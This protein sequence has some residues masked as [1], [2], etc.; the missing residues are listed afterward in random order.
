MQVTKNDQ[1]GRKK[2]HQ[3]MMWRSA[4]SGKYGRIIVH[5]VLVSVALLITFPLFIVLYRYMPDLVLPFDG[6]VYRLDHILSF[7]VI[8]TVVRV[9]L[10]LIEH[11]MFYVMMIIIALVLMSHFTGWYTLREMSQRYADLLTLVES[12]PVR[13]PFLKDEKMTIRNAR[14]IREAI[15]YKKPEVRNYAI[16]ISQAN[17]NDRALLRE[18]GNVI[19][20]FSVF[21]EIVK[22]NYIP[23]PVGEEYYAKASESMN[24]L[25]GDCDDYSILM[26]ACIKAIGGEVRLIHTTNHLYPEVKICHISDFAKITD[27]I[28]RRLYLKE[29]LGGNIYYHLDKDDNVWLNFDYTSRYPG[30]PFMNEAILGIL[31]I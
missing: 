11:L 17:F 3:A 14:Q 28:K 29:S 23:D 10:N 22:W 13:I 30:G 4:R 18:Y 6:E 26:A 19:R 8:F 24:H 9:G 7:L 20:Y 1:R 16:T 25:S 5:A 2:L 15:D 12:R 31:N 27:L 21:T